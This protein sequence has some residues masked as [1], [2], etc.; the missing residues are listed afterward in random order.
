MD[1]AQA[2]QHLHAIPKWALKDHGKA[3]VRKIKCRNFIEAVE[4]INSIKDIAEYENHH[5]DVHLTNYKNLEIE[6]TTHAVGHL[7]DSDFNVA[8]KIEELIP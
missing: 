6:L 5:P 7:T 3:I 1:K 4:F 8:I 2:L